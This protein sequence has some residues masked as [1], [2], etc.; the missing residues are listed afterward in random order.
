[1]DW[2]C[3]GKGG[4]AP[5]W[6]PSP[7]P[8]DPL[9]P[10]PPAQASP[11][12]RGPSRPQPTPPPPHIAPWRGH[13]GGVPSRPPYLTGLWRRIRD[14]PGRSHG[15]GSAP[16]DP[17]NCRGGTHRPWDTGPCRQATPPMPCGNQGVWG[18][19][20]RTSSPTHPRAP[21]VVGRPGSMSL[22]P[23]GCVALARI[24][25]GGLSVRLPKPPQQGPEH[26]AYTLPTAP[27]QPSCPTDSAYTS[28]SMR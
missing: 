2:V 1:M 24:S 25:S 10:P 21:A 27:L 16:W 5:P 9:T 7:P 6:T 13:S 4:G 18:L 23:G 12:P 17:S 26:R 20:S 8:L 14:I 22:C 3:S 28:T 15:Q 11:C 19:P